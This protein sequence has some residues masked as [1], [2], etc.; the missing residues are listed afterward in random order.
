MST[1]D[2]GGYAFP[3]KQPL[4][5][6]APGMTLRDYFAANALVA[7][8]T[9]PKWHEGQSG[10]ILTILQD[11][12]FAEAPQDSASIYAKAAYVLADTMLKER[13]K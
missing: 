7:L 5:S 10:L 6:D 3:Q 2:E 1:K 13:D 4:L 12:D 9:E 8:I 11:G